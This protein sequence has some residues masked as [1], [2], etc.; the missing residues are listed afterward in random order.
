MKNKFFTR[1]QD[2]INKYLSETIDLSEGVSYSQH[3]LIKRMMKFKNKDLAGSKIDDDLR[4]IYYTDIITPRA[5][6]EKK[7]I[8]IDTKHIRFFSESPSKDFPA[9]FTLN[10]KVRDWM[11]NNGQG[12]LLNKA[13]DQFTDFGNVGF[14]KVKDGYELIDPLN[15]YVTNQTAETVEDT[16]LIERHEMTAS[17]IMA[18]EDWENKEQVINNIGQKSKSSTENATEQEQHKDYFE[19]YEYTGDI[20]EKHYNQIKGKEGGDEYE[21]LTA[22]IIVAGLDDG[23]TKEPIVLFAEEIKE[24]IEDYYIFAHR[25]SYNGRFWRE[26]IYEQLFDLQI[27]ANE[28]ANN[29]ASGLEWA[30]KIFFKT[31]SSGILQNIRT[32]LKNGDIIESEDL[33]QVDTR[34]HGLDQLISDWNRINEQAD[35]V[36]NSFEVV[37]GKELKS[38]TPF[39]LGSLMDTNAN[40]FFV[41]LRQNLTL[42]FKKVFENWVLPDMINDLKDQDLINVVGDDEVLDD[43][44]ELAAKQ[45]FY[46]NLAKIGPHSAAIRETLIEAKAQE[47]SD[48]DPLL[49]NR[50]EFWKGVKNRIKVTIS[51]EN[52]DEEEKLETIS[53][54]LQVEE[55][56]QRRA[57]L[58]DLVYKIKGIPTPPEIEQPRQKAPKQQGLP[59]G[60]VI[61]GQQGFETQTGEQ[62]VEGEEPLEQ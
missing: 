23:E 9:V 30:S 24:G 14:K 22:K 1:L 55:D 25:G 59:Q 47:L 32:D 57:Y 37:M 62:P 45:W 60:G 53:S 18:M 56:P 54:L 11:M 49:K 38:G 46:N 12:N 58:L 48:T 3:R 44:R 33:A 31:A 36:A 17:D 10:A 7:N 26:G 39:R 28:I 2:E 29:I 43:L 6:S 27:R 4:Y 34:L 5:R 42:P 13:V 41:L 16:D 8:R 61:P 20:T 51:G 21:T 40:K 52:Y 19:I 50:E 35:L 15:L